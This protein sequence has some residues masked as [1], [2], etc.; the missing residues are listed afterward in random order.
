M[1]PYS[2]AFLLVWIIQ[3][4]VWMAFDLPLGPAAGVFFH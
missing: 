3:V 1:L 2:I 4:C